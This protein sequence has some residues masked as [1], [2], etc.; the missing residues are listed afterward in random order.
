MID[1]DAANICWRRHNRL[2]DDDDDDD[3]DDD[4]AV[5]DHSSCISMQLAYYI[6]SLIYRPSRSSIDDISD[7][8]YDEKTRRS[9]V[10][11]KP[12]FHYPS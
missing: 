5:N 1:D 6:Q 8:V 7:S 2:R 12:G 10:F 4:G 9:D 3:D 11:L